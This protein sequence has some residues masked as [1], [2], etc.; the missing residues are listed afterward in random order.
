MRGTEEFDQNDLVWAVKQSGLTSLSEMDTSL[1]KPDNAK[2]IVYLLPDTEVP[3]W[4]LTSLGH[5]LEMEGIKI[6]LDSARKRGQ[7]GSINRLS[8][9]LALV[10]G[11]QTQGNVPG[12]ILNFAVEE[13]LIN[14]T[15]Y[16]LE[17]DPASIV[18]NKAFKL[19]KSRGY[20]VDWIRGLVYTD[21][22][23]DLTQLVADVIAGNT[24]LISYIAKIDE[25]GKPIKDILKNH[26]R[27]SQIP[28]DIV[29]KQPIEVI[30]ML[31]GCGYW[32]TPDFTEIQDFEGL[33][34]SPF[35]Q[36]LSEE[37]VESLFL[38]SDDLLPRDFFTRR[39]Y[40]NDD[41][42]QFLRDVLNKGSLEFTK[43]LLSGEHHRYEAHDIL[44]EIFDEHVRE[45]TKLIWSKEKTLAYFLADDRSI[46]SAESISKL[47]EM[48]DFDSIWALKS[49]IKHKKQLGP[50][51]GVYEEQE[52][53]P[54]YRFLIDQGKPEDIVEDLSWLSDEMRLFLAVLSLCKNQQNLLKKLE[55]SLEGI[56][57]SEDM[58]DFLTLFG[59]C[60]SILRVNWREIL[61]MRLST[62]AI[63]IPNCLKR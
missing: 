48:S 28:I 53:L 63:D 24:S 39:F 14:L 8:L 16:L 33:K 21:R 62:E 29:Y 15:R 6:I 59:I 18:S 42:R 45:G 35:G 11:C 26:V 43:V 57:L 1:L 32:K 36:D 23:V 27:M 50:Y 22:I 12:G 55:T 25:A 60:V 13:G 47:I 2:L 56:E 51:S 10:K 41:E 52:L 5:E 19:A 9:S 34:S 54:Y 17:M 49:V 31:Y 44:G 4:I 40:S 38:M 58:K 3:R 46:D 61:L 30:E 7:D 37:K 20:D